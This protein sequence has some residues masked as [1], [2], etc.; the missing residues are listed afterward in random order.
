[1]PSMPPLHLFLYQ[2]SDTHLDHLFILINQHLEACSL[3]QG[4][5]S[6]DRF[7][8]PSFFFLWLD[9]AVTWEE[10]LDCIISSHLVRL[11][12]FIHFLFT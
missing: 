2:F 10:I 8:F 5:C 3:F 9:V 1:M 11:N 6:I 7:L 4:V 12:V